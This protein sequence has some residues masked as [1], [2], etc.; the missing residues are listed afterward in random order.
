MALLADL[1]GLGQQGREL[2]VDPVGAVRRNAWSTLW[3]EYTSDLRKTRRARTR[4]SQ[5]V[6]WMRAAKV[7]RTCRAIRVFWGRTHLAISMMRSKVARTWGS[8]PATWGSSCPRVAQVWVGLALAH[9]RP[10]IGQVH[11]GRRVIGAG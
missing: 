10:D 8:L 1:V 3:G 4:S 6:R 9:V 11:R 7:I 5:W 2:A